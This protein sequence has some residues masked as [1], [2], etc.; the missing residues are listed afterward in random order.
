MWRE[1]KHT[2]MVTTEVC[3]VAVI[4]SKIYQDVWITEK[5]WETKWTT[6]NF[7]FFQ[8]RQKLKSSFSLKQ[9]LMI[10]ETISTAFLSFVCI[11]ALKV[12]TKLMLAERISLGPYHYHH[13]LSETPPAA[14]SSPQFLLISF[15]YL[16]IYWPC[17]AL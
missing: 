6:H 14:T 8:E 5:K 4:Y 11:L 9:N 17:K 13:Q 3:H 10:S 16:F 12:C 7:H 1:A 15:F 2:N